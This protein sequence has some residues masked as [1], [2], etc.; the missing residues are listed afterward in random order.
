[1]SSR[2][3][4]DTCYSFVLPSR[5]RNARAGGAV[6][7]GPLECGG[8]RRFGSFFLFGVESRRW[9]PRKQGETTYRKRRRPPHSKVPRPLRLKLILSSRSSASE[10]CA[11]LSG[12]CADLV[13]SSSPRGDVLVRVYPQSPRSWYDFFGRAGLGTSIATGR[14][15]GSVVGR[16][17][18]DQ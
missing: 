3:Q 12:Q 10:S 17:A 1:M 15:V 7:G 14:T 8:L 18:V 2:S 13:Q 6:C 11:S 4:H 5:K 9:Q 16:R